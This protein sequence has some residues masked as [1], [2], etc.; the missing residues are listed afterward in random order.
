MAAPSESAAVPLISSGIAGLD[1]VLHGGLRANRLYLLEGDPGAGKTTA[2]LQ[3]LLAGVKN[4]EACMFVTLSESAE[5]LRAS[6][7][8]HGWSLEGMHVLEVVA[9][10]DKLTP[11]ARYTMFHPSEVELSETVKGVLTEAS[12]VKPT[13]L[14]FDSLSELRL[15]A[16]NPLRYRRQILA[17][18]HHFARAQ[19]TVLLVD[20]RTGSTRDMNLHS[21]AHGAISLERQTAEYGTMRRQL[22][23]RK[24]R[25]RSFREGFHDFSILSGGIRVYPRLVASEH[26][27]GYS[28]DLVSS[29]LEAF[30]AL[31]AGGLARGTSTLIMGPAGT[32]KSSLATQFAYAA[33]ARGECSTMLLFDES[34]AALLQR[35]SGLGMPLEPLMER[36]IVNVRQI[37]PAELSPGEF[38]AAVREAVEVGDTRVLVI[39]SLSGFLNAMPSERFLLLHLHELLT[40]L[41]H[42]GVTTLLV[43]IQ[44]GMVGSDSR[45][46]FDASYLADTVLLLRHYEVAGE[47]RQALSVIKKR[48]GRHERTI[49]EL[50]FDD[51]IEVGEPIRDLQGVL[52][53]M[54]Q[55]LVP[56]ADV[57]PRSP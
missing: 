3:F 4:G 40:Y 46:A 15:L 54:P 32:G 14:V 57:P 31:L 9:S 50:R 56:L 45:S 17:L 28:R 11:D 34:V 44:H 48:T 19:C 36:G 27:T 39:D 35:S 52:S 29:G 53:G 33:A 43:M 7:E 13:R 5:E 26:R 16:E 22:E 23:V 49:R 1:D 6:A 21:L 18:K 37:D 51:R 12:R 47:I 25:G 2:A 24:M 55:C 10:E 8:S 42:K 41:N 30:D 20:D 38:V